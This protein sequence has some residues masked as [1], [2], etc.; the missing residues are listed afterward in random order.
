MLT[1]DLLVVGNTPLRKVIVY[2]VIINDA[3]L[4]NLY[5]RG[6]AV[7]FSPL[8]NLRQVFLLGIY[9]PRDKTSPT[10]KRKFCPLHGT[11]YGTQ[12]RGRRLGTYMRCGGVLTFS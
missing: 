9:A 4:K 2:T 3:V 5:E 10:A 1:H 8:K 12:R 11:V 7:I 6:T